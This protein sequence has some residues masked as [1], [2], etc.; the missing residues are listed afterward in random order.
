MESSRRWECASVRDAHVQTDI[1]ARDPEGKTL[2]Q[3][4]A[5]RGAKEVVA[6]LLKKGA[7]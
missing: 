4:A 5:M 2:L 3:Y 1:F 7:V 6:L